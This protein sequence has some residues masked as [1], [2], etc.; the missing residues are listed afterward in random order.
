VLEAWK[1]GRI[2]D[3][4]KQTAAQPGEELAALRH[5]IEVYSAA[6]NRKGVAIEAAIRIWA[7]Q[8]AATAAVVEQVDAA[9]LECTRALFVA[10]GLPAAEADARSVLLYAFVFGFSMMQCGRFPMDAAATQ[11]W[12]AERIAQ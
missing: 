3:I 6:K 12:I 1:D 9:R 5:T 10:L 4:R 7:R 8:D 2:R 11:R